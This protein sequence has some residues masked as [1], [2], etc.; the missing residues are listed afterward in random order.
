MQIDRVYCARSRRC[1]LLLLLTL[2]LAFFLLVLLELVFVCLADLLEDLPQ[3]ALLLQIREGVA[4]G[5]PPCHLDELPGD[6]R[7]VLQSIL[8]LTSDVVV[9][10]NVHFHRDLVFRTD[11]S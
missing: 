8:E 6:L 1:L 4:A 3:L 2:P 7:V 9:A 10:Q 5:G 11:T